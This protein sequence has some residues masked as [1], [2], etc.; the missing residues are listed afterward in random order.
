MLSSGKNEPFFY[1][2]YLTMAASL[3]VISEQIFMWSF[4]NTT[5]FK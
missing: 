3:T 4:S 5:Y 1:K 2:E